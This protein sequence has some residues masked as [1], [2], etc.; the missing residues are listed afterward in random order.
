MKDSATRVW[1]RRLYTAPD[2]G[3]LVAMDTR[4]RLFPP[5]L[6][7]LVQARDATCRTP[8]C[9]APIRHTDHI[10]PWRTTGSTSAPGGQGLCESCN[11][12]KEIPGWASRPLPGPRHTVERR[13]PTGHAYRSTAPPLPGAPPP[14][15]N[16]RPAHPVIDLIIH[17]HAA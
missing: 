13:T 8:Y 10:V 17:P 16:H 2:T 5:G 7:R 12:T 14:L 11:Y 3:Q 1:L 4:S 9:D 6:R 15:E